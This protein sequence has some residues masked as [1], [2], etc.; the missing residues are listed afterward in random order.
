MRLLVFSIIVILT[1]LQNAHARD[2]NRS[3]FS[4]AASFEDI[5]GNKYSSVSEGR[6]R[7]S[8]DGIYCSID[9]PDYSSSYPCEV[10]DRG[11]TQFGISISRNTLLTIYRKLVRTVTPWPQATLERFDHLIELVRFRATG[12]YPGYEWSQSQQLHDN[13]KA[14]SVHVNLRGGFAWEVY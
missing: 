10:K 6:I 13:E 3:H 7:I 1:G 11:R 5:E 9:L 4:I 14:D 2:F 12:N 8:S